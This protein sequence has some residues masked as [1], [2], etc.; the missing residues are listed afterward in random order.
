MKLLNCLKSEKFV[1]DVKTNYIYRVKHDCLYY[2]YNIE[3][4]SL[5]FPV[6]FKDVVTTEYMVDAEFVEYVE[7]IR[8]RSFL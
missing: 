3:E 8:F 1:K 7:P 2:S 6:S 5:F 4:D